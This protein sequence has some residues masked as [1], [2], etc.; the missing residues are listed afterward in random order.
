MPTAHA[1]KE[2]KD[3]IEIATV[4]SGMTFSACTE[5]LTIWNSAVLD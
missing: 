1:V 4:C 2:K 3:H 5:D